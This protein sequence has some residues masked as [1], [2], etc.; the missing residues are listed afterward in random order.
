MRIGSVVPLAV[1]ARQHA[2]V[3]VAGRL[4]AV[5]QGPPWPLATWLLLVFCLRLPA[6]FF[7][8]GFAYPDQQYQYIDPAWHLAT[9]QAWHRTWEWIDGIRSSVYPWL[10][11]AVFRGLHAVGFEDPMWTMRAVRAVHALVS[12]LPAWWFWLFVVR[13]RPLQAPRPALLLFAVSGLL[14]TG[15]QASGPAFATSLVLAAAI[16]MQGRPLFVFAGGLCLGL[17]FC[18]RFQDALFGPGFLAVLLLQR[19]WS[20]ALAL[21]LGCAPGICLQGCVDLAEHGGFLATPWRYLQSNLE[22]GAAEKWT[23]QPF[24]FYW[25]AG[26][27]PVLGLVPGC[28]RVAWQRVAAG[29]SAMPVA[30]VGALG[31]LLLHSC[32]SRKALRFEYPALAILLAVLCAGLAVVSSRQSAAARWHLRLVSAVHVA[33]FLWASFWFGNR[34]AVQAALWLRAQPTF[35]GE[36]LVVDGDPTS[37][38]GYYYSRPPVDRA[39][40]LGRGPFAEQVAKQGPLPEEFVVAVREP[41][42]DD[43]REQAGLELAVAFHGVFS[44]R[45]SENRFLYRRRR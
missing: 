36:V 22:G 25:A 3:N 32:I 15:V 7:A 18:A 10:L 1:S 14:I 26:V 42:A 9:G 21:A 8:D 17:A 45:R 29:A 11:A 43:L 23:K 28:L 13:W 5:A 37:L 30:T 2:G 34:S 24:W 20:A 33:L 16:A 35:A 39:R 27:V 12:L 19:R 6:V 40:G 4:A 41:L 31:H 44:L 38:G